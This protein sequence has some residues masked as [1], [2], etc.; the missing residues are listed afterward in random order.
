MVLVFASVGYESNTLATGLSLH[1]IRLDYQEIGAWV[2]IYKR[3]S[4][5]QTNDRRELKIWKANNTLSNP[6]SHL[7]VHMVS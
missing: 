2:Y 1:I 5:H 3:S 6:K 4:R 7:L